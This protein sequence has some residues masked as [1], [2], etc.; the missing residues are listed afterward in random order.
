MHGVRLGVEATSWRA[1]ADHQTKSFKPLHLRSKMH[2]I[3]AQMRRNMV[4]A[5][6]TQALSAFRC[7][8]KQA[9]LAGVRKIKAEDSARNDNT[10]T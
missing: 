10:T 7:F 8:C 6:P 5:W 4:Y 2:N 9:E 3:E 1:S